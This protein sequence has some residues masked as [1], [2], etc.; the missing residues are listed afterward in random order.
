MEEPLARLEHSICE[1]YTRSSRHDHFPTLNH[2]I[3]YSPREHDGPDT[4]CK[5]LFALKDD[6]VKR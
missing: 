5:K 1:Q 2:S 3:G 4:V 6:D